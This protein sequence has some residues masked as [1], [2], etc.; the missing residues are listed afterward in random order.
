MIDTHQLHDALRFSGLAPDV[1]FHATDSSHE[2]RL[3]KLIRELTES[4]VRDERDL[5]IMTLQA[6][7]EELERELDEVASERDR[8]EAG[9]REAKRELNA[10]G[11]AELAAVTP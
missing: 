1:P 10:R 2:L 3:Q 6:R 4:N 5:E 11:D 7:V 9:W 8:A